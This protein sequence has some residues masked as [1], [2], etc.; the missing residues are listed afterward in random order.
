MIRALLIIL[1]ALILASCDHAPGKLVL[2]R[3]DAPIDQEIAEDLVALFDDESAINLVLSDA[4]MTGGE[5]LVEVAEGRADIA[6]VSNDQPFRG[7]IATVIPLY[8]TVLHIVRIGNQESESMADLLRN[9][10]VFAGLEGSAS[11]R[12]FNRLASSIDLGGDH[13]RFETDRSTDV[14]LA[15]VFAPIS[16]ERLAE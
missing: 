16:P 3:P 6:L 10:S 5:A 15:V 11:R 9:A 1:F 2:V 4:A 7:D 12:V 8:A 13:Y 14:D